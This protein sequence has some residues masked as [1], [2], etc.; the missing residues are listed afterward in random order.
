MEY[1]FSNVEEGTKT[2]SKSV[3]N[4]R[5]NE[6]KKIHYIGRQISILLP[7]NLHYII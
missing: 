1:L 7:Y 6:I 4:C 5:L 2:V 3:H